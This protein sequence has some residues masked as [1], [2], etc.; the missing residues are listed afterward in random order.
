MNKA[1]VSIFIISMTFMSITHSYSAE[2][3]SPPLFPL[4]VSPPATMKRPPVT[5]IK[6]GDLNIQLESTK[7]NDVLKTINAGEIRHHG[8]ASE[9]VHWLCYSISN[10]ANPVR[11]WIMS[12]EIDGGYVGSIVARHVSA[13]DKATQT[14]PELPDAFQPVKLDRKIWIQ[15]NESEIKK[16]LGKPSLIIND[17]MHYNSERKRIIR[18]AEFFELGSVS[19]RFINGQVVEL[20]VSKTTSN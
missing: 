17:W 1:I 10:V 15:T 7:L 8:D 14:C 2:D 9:S 5:S 19:L 11:I 20:W 6:F 18:G 4:N 12:G 3:I 16:S 13:E